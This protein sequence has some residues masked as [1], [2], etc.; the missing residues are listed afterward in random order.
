[1]VAGRLEDRVPGG[2]RNLHVE[3]GGGDVERLTDSASN[4]SSPAWNPQPPSGDE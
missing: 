3:L 1:M 2:W 4:D